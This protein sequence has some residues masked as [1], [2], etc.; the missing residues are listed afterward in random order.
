MGETGEVAEKLKKIQ[1]NNN[2]KM[3][4][5]ERT[6]LLKELGDALWY[7]SAI[8]YYLKEPLSSIAEKNLDKVLDRKARGVVK[9]SG[10][11]R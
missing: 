10:D 2:G 1:R 4:E 11:N 6:E 9:S 7:L 8:A 3:S 5:A